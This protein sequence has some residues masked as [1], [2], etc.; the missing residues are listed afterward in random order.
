MITAKDWPAGHASLRLHGAWLK[1]HVIH[2]DGLFG[3][4]YFHSLTCEEDFRKPEGYQE[5]AA[6]A[7][8]AEDPYAGLKSCGM[9][10]G[11]IVYS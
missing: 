6:A 3:V 5:D 9:E 4:G 10:V 2:S 8:G 1:V 7:Q 11:A